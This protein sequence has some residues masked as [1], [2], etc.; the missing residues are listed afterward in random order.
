MGKDHVLEAK[1][2]MGSEDLGRFSLEGKIPAVMFSLGA[3]DP[4]KLEE[5]LKTGVPLSSLHSS[6]FAPVY[7][8]AIPAGVTAMT[9]MALDLL[10]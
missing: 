7:A 9:A 4:T 10:K 3:S 2:V 1:P 6:L 5:S 8:D